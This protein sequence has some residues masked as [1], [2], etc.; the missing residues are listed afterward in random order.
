VKAEPK[1][2]KNIFEFHGVAAD[3]GDIQFEILNL[4]K[5]S[6]FEKAQSRVRD[7]QSKKSTYPNYKAKTDRLFDHSSELIKAIE[8][9]I[10]FPNLNQL[11]QSK[12]DE[13]F[14]KIY[15]N[16]EDLKLSL[17][18]I[19]SIE[20]DLMIQ[21]SRSSIYVVKAVLFSVVFLLLVYIFNEFS[22]GFTR[23]ILGFVHDTTN[24]FY[25]VVDNL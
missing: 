15:E 5:S 19:Q 11:P 14:L 22:H 6:N 23:Q 1:D 2:I 20:R 8:A 3:L 21:D 7:F 9:K 25:E 12:Q 17:R 24:L 16:W 4:V 13:I 18:R 10:K